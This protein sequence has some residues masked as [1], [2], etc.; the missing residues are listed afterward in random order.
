VTGTAVEMT[1]NLVEKGLATATQVV[2]ECDGQRIIDESYGR[3]SQPHGAPSI[4]SQS[5]FL[6]ASITKPVTALAVMMCSERTVLDLED[7][8]SKH[9]PEFSGSRRDKVRIKHLLNH[10]S[11]LPDML[12]GNEELRRRNA[13]RSEFIERVCS[14]PLLF[15]PGTEFQYQSMG[16][17]L[18]GVIVERM[19]DQTLGTFMRE[20]I[21]EPLRM[22]NTFLGMGD[23]SLEEMVSCDVEPKDGAGDSNRWD[24]NSQYW[25][26]FGAPWGGLHSTAGDLASILNLFLNP[27]PENDEEML[28]TT[29]RARMI[30]DQTSGSDQCWGYG[31]ALRDSRDYFGTN[32]SRRT[33]GHGGATGTLAWADPEHNIVFVCL[34]TLPLE[35]HPEGFFK[36]C[37]NR[38][39]AT[40]SDR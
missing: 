27:G 9:L 16:Y 37:S 1:E 22:D 30:D 26:D 24:W 12:P 6:V 23:R 38:I 40:L 33:Y 17:L 36:T 21:F 11:G 20:E 25:R 10:T 7:S 34:T 28:S 39:V 14:T 18:A 5:P 31:W 3:R 2:V 13:P 29:S 4:D 35:N 15:E 8:V 32:S 19:T